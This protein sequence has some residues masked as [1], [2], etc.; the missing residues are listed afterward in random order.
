MP[1]IEGGMSDRV[2]SKEDIVG[3]LASPDANL[4]G[5]LKTGH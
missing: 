2:W 3:L 1:A 4:G 5:Q